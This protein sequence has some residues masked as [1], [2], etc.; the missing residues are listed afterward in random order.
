VATKAALR[1][2]FLAQR[3]AL[4]TETID[5]RSQKIADLFFMM[6]H[7]SSLLD[8]ATAAYQTPFAGGALN[9]KIIHIFL[10]ILRQNE[11]NTWPII[12]RLWQDFPQI[13]LT[14]SVTDLTTNRLL[15]YQITPE[16]PLR[17]NRWG[18]PE[19]VATERQIVSSHVI[20]AVLVPL[21]V[22]DERGHRVGYGGGF[23][24]RFLAECRP[25]CLKI[26]LSLFE[27]VEQ[28][29][30]VEP[31]DIRLNSYLTPEQIYIFD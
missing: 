6:A 10:P 5:Q 1:A 11:V 29:D 12:H 25:D 2:R 8:A 7:E 26:G 13:C 16:T 24:D 9:P 18:I 22:F 17:E 28:I 3:R 4:S 30:D 19:P 27:P 23:Y 20:D 14:V 21:L 15:H 31:T